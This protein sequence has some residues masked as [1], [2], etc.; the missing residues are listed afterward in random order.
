MEDRRLVK[1]VKKEILDTYLADRVKARLMQPD[2][3]YVHLRN[4]SG[5]EPLDAQAWFMQHHSTTTE[6]AAQ[7][8]KPKQP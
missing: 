7:P 2:G 3:T 5:G 4:E 1:R 8:S 6:A